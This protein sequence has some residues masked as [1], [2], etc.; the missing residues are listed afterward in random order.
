MISREIVI[1]LFGLDY[2]ASIIDIQ[3]LHLVR[4]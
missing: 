1:S 3:I 4:R 2:Q